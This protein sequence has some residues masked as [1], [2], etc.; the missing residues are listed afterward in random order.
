MRRRRIQT[1]ASTLLLVISLGLLVAVGALYLRDRNDDNDPIPPTPIPGHNE[2]V[3]VVR[4]FQAH[5]LDAEIDAR[6]T[7]LERPGQMVQIGD[8][9][10][11]VYIYPDRA[12]Q[13]TATLD[14]LPED[15]E[16]EDGAGNPIEFESIELFTSSNVAVVLLDADDETTERVAEAVAGLT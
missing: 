4:A 9:R 11:Y 12:S 6:R 1:I 2:L 16:L 3:H 10:A 8:A 13:E 15:I 5:D 7:T 14:V